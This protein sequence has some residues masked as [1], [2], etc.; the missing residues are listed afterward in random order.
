[1][2]LSS[3]LPTSTSTR[4]WMSPKLAWPLSVLLIGLVG[5]ALWFAWQA[6]RGAQLPGTPAT[7]EAVEAQYGIRITHIAVLADGGLVDFRF[8]V[9][10]PDKAGPLFS[11]DN[12]PILIVEGTGQVVDSLYHPP[13]S[14]N[15]IAGQ[16]SYFLYNDHK[17]AI[18]RGVLVSILLGDLRLEHIVAQ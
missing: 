17:G 14:H 11:L 10:D 1:M 3:T 15:I 6:Y 18:Q 7:A 2:N 5:V 13:H 16:S 12:R 4:K 8:Q 9:I